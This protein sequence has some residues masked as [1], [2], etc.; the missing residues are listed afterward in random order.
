MHAPHHAL[1]LVHP[2]FHLSF[3]IALSLLV[4]NG[5]GVTWGPYK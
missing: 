2:I 4:L 3:N 1:Q 5:H